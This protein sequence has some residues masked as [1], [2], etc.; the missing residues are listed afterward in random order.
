MQFTELIG[1]DYKIF[2]FIAGK[3]FR[4]TVLPLQEPEI[5]TLKIVEIVS[6]GGLITETSYFVTGVFLL[7][8]IV[9]FL[10]TFLY[11]KFRTK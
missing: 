7:L 1:G 11:R 5:V 6:I 9:V 2:V 8:L 4:I 10:T 3:P